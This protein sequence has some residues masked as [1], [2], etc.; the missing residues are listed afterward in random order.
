MRSLHEIQP[1][2]HL[3]MSSPHQVSFIRCNVSHIGR[4]IAQT[5]F[6]GARKKGGRGH[7]FKAAER[8]R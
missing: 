5:S 2:R 3:G 4:A 1:T 8:E 7:T 6:H